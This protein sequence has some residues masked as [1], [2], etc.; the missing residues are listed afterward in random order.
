M[1]FGISTLIKFSSELRMYISVAAS[2]LRRMKV[3]FGLK[4]SRSNLFSSFLKCH[5]D[6]NILPSAS[7]SALI[8]FWT[9]PYLFPIYKLINSALSSATLM[10]LPQEIFNKN[11]HGDWRRQESKLNLT[12]NKQWN[13]STCT[14]LPLGANWTHGLIAQSVITSEHNSVVAISN[15]ANYIYFKEESFS[16][17][18]NVYLYTYIY[19]YIIYT[20]LLLYILYIL[21]Y[22]N[23]IIYIC[24]IY[25]YICSTYI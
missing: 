15:H 7:N 11:K 12:L 6:L 14:N 10:W 1:S 20:Y 4:W 18:Y 24:F 19:I 13:W 9:L 25:I 8:P 22:I 2:L 21:Y 23:Y 5:F 17:E 3:D 16:S